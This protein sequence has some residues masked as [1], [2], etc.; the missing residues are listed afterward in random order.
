MDLALMTTEQVLEAIAGGIDTVI[1]PVGSSEQHGPYLALGTDTFAA[2]LVAKRL[3]DKVGAI[4]APPLPYGMSAN[5][6]RFPGTITLSASTLALVTKE[7]CLSLT[8]SGFRH[9]IFVNGHMG[10]YHSIM[11]GAREAKTESDVLIL[12][13]N[14]W[15]A[16]RE[17]YREL[18]GEE[19]T[20]LRFR[21]FAGHG[22]IMEMSLVLATYEDGFVPEKVVSEE[23]DL[24]ELAE[25][26]AVNFISDV[27]DVSSSGVYGYAG[28][29][30]AELGERIAEAAANYLA[31]KV[32]VMIE[33]FGSGN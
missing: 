5:H 33:T 31:E 11:V 2:S 16:L 22:A 10:N 20:A 4:L 8:N 29:P 27:E 23:C 28:Q 24:V 19:A 13:C 15:N 3:A 12:V 25:D 9:I 18:M 14:Y 32:R 26:P 1:V 6:R 21:E 17:S 30:S 7:I